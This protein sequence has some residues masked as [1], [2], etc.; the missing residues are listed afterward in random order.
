MKGAHARVVT[1]NKILEDERSH[2]RLKGLFILINCVFGSETDEEKQFYLDLIRAEYINKGGGIRWAE[3][4]AEEIEVNSE[5]RE[6]KSNLKTL[7]T[8]MTGENV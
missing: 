5:T 1:I 4:E 7:L 6:I 3:K 2:P 8:S